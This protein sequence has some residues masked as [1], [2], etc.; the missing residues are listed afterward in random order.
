MTT[1]LSFIVF[2]TTQQCNL[3]CRY[4]YNVWKTPHHQTSCKSSY[5]QA[6]KSLKR[7]FKVA[8]VRQVTMSGG[9]PF[10][11]D[12]FL[13]TVLFCRM[14]GKSVNIITNG[15]TATR[16]EYQQAHQLGVGMFQLPFHSP[17]PES[18]EKM[19]GKP[20]SWKKS[21]ESMEYLLS[22][23]AKVSA[24]VI[25]TSVNAAEVPRT[26]DALNDMGIKSILFNRFN[27]GGRG[28]AE[29]HWL[30]PS[31]PDLR[32]AF[33]DA[34]NAA[35]KYGMHVNSGVCTPR[36]L[37]KPEKHPHIGFAFCEPDVSRRPITMDLLGNL[38][39]CNHSPVNM[40]NIFKDDLET[41][42]QSQYALTW[43]RSVP[44]PCQ[45]CKVFDKCFGG[46]RAAAEQLG[47]TLADGD[48]VLAQCAEPQ[49]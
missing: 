24:V 42:V 11:S 9:E 26:F 28:I 35:A 23:G 22:L 5:S 21:K 39:F 4:C 29:S 40:G 12:R 37:V 49:T 34:E 20:G 15:N 14:Q 8:D 43:K 25:V 41:M 19:T 46:C 2:E 32:Q 1:Q 18:H 13:E 17:T 44:A 36:C 7:L 38:R 27:I 6:M 3:D 10:L 30:S 45:K 31:V 47:T 48:P 16:E 33:R